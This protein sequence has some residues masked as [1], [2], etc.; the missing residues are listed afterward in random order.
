MFDDT[1]GYRIL[2]QMSFKLDGVNG[3]AL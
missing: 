3:V 2:W 1:G